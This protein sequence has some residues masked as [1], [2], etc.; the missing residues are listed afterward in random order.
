MDTYGCNDVALALGV[1]T[2][3]AQDADSS[4]DAKTKPPITQVAG[5]WS[6]PSQSQF[7]GDGTFT[8]NLR[9]DGKKLQDGKKTDGSFTL[10]AS[11]ANPS[12]PVVGKIS[13]DGLKLKL[14]NTSSQPECPAKVMATVDGNE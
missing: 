5:T 14:K 3:R 12:G 10:D 8:L 13:C 9:Q 4:P 6:G 2:V 7:D 1:G 11:N